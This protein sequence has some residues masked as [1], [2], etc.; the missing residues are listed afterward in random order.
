MFRGRVEKIVFT[1]LANDLKIQV[2]QMFV[3]LTQNYACKDIVY[4]Y[5]LHQMTSSILEDCG[6]MMQ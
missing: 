3:L 5:V 1:D 6:W 4:R 2:K